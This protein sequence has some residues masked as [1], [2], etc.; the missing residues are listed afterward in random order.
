MIIKS[1]LFNILAIIFTSNIIVAQEI[2]TTRNRPRPTRENISDE[3]L[4]MLKSNRSKQ[5]EFRNAFRESLSGNQLDIL[6]NPELSKE[7]KIKAFR[8]SLSGNQ[9]SMMK[10]HRKEIRVQ[11]NVLMNT[12]GNQQRMRI[13]KM[14]VSRTQLNRAL[15]RRARLNRRPPR[16]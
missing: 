14:A 1:V 3:Q 12:L 16:I 2:A 15:Y 11:K 4:A 7:S 6:T 9:V 10:T 5:I 8:E 13:R